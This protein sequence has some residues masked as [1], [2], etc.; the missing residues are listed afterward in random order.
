MHSPFPLSK[1]ILK[2]I[3]SYHLV[4]DV[5]FYSDYINNQTSTDD[6]EFSSQYLVGREYN[7]AYFGDRDSHRQM[8]PSPISGWW[9]RTA[10]G[11][12]EAPRAIEDP[13]H[14]ANVSHY[15]LPTLLSRTGQNVNA[16][17][18]VSVYEYRILGKGPLRR[19]VVVLP[20]RSQRGHEDEH[21]HEHEHEHEHEKKGKHGGHQKK[22]RHE[23]G[24]KP[25]KVWKA[26]AVVRNGAVHVRSFSYLLFILPS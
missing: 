12:R 21:D 15:V 18:K 6:G 26:D 13:H 10:N 14:K 20:H 11:D 7:V 3:L 25:V 9:P 1:K 17:L 16:T 8:L 5:A 24:V 2:Y 22:E 23:E 4:P 19:A